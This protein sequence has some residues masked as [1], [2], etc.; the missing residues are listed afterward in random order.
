MT[1]LFLGSCHLLYAQQINVTNRGTVIRIEQDALVSINGNY[2]DISG[3]GDPTQIESL[4]NDPESG[5]AVDAPIFLSGTLRIT[6]NIENYSITGS[7]LIFEFEGQ[8][9]TGKVILAGISDQAIGGSKDSYFP[10]LE[11]NKTGNVLLQKSIF[12]DNNLTLTAGNINLN[13][14]NIT[15]GQV[16]SIVSETGAN[17]IFG[18]PGNV[19]TA[20]YPI[21]PSASVTN[22]RGIGLGYTTTIQN[23]SNVKFYRTHGPGNYMVAD[24]VNVLRVYRMETATMD[25]FP[26]VNFYYHDAELNGVPE[27]NIALYF[28]NNGGTSW[29]KASSTVNTTSNIV[30]AYNVAVTSGANNLFTLA[31]SNCST[32]NR[33]DVTITSPSATIAGNSMNICEQQSFAIAVPNVST[34]YYQWT[35]PDGNRN[36]YDYT[37]ASIVRPD[38]TGT[39]SIFARN[40]RGCENTSAL[41]VNVRSI[42]SPQFSISPDPNTTALCFGNELTLDDISTTADMSAITGWAWD[43]GDVSNATASI[44]SPQFTYTTFGDKTPSLVVTSQYGCVSA[45]ATRNITIQSL[46]TPDFTITDGANEITRICEDIDAHFINHS[47]YR[48]YEGN[49]TSSLSYHWDFGDT[50]SSSAH[51]PIHAFTTHNTYTITLT[52]T[53]TATTCYQTFSKDLIINPEPIPMFTPTIGG[54]AIAEVCAGVY[55][56]FDNTTTMPGGTG[57]TYQWDFDDGNASTAVSPVK[58]FDVADLN[59]IKLTATSVEFGCY[60]SHT[61]DVLVNPPPTGHFA[62]QDPDICLVEE[63]VFTNNSTISSGTLTYQWDFADG[64]SSTEATPEVRHTYSQPQLYKVSLT[65][66][67]NK[68][69]TNVVTRNLTVHPTPVPAF[70]QL[71][72]CDGNEVTF[73]N[74]SVIQSDAIA[75]FLWDFNDGTTSAATAP[76]HIFPQ[77]GIHSVS[78]TATSTFGC[79]NTISGSVEVYRNPVFNLGASVAG[80]TVPYTIDPSS[81]VAAYL[82][83]G[84]TFTWLNAAQEPLANTSQL[85]VNTSGV[86]RA[87]ITTP[88]PQSCTSSIAV[89]FFIFK[90][91]S[92][93]LDTVA[94]AQIILDAERGLP[95]EKMNTDQTSYEWRKNGVVVST[96]QTITAAETG[97]YTVTVTRTRA[98]SSCSSSDDVHVTIELPLTVTLPAQIISCEGQSLLLDAGV[99]ADTYLWTHIDTGAPMGTSSTLSVTQSGTYKLEVTNGTCK[100][101]SVSAITISPL[102]AVSFGVSASSGCVGQPVTLTDYSF[103]NVGTITSS[104]WNFG[105]NT[106]A[107]NQAVANKS[108]VS[109]GTYSIT[110]TGTT[111]HGCNNTYSLQVVINPAPNVDF[112]ITDVCTNEFASIQNNTLPTSATFAWNFGDGTESN[113]F[114]PNKSFTDDGQFNVTLT[115]SDLGCSSSVTRTVTINPLPD[116]DFGDQVTTCGNSLLLDALNPG[117]SYKWFDPSNGNTTLSTA[118]QYTVSTNQSIGLEITN[119]FGC[120][121]N[122]VTTVNLNVPIV[123]NLGPNRSVCDA[124]VLDAGYF[125]GAQYAWSTSE[126]TRAVDVASSGTYSV[127]I[128]DQNGCT[129]NASVLLEVNVTPVVS[130]GADKS[131]CEGEQLTLDAGFNSMFTYSWSTGA[132]SSSINVTTAGNY[133]VLVSNSNCS[134]SESVEVKVNAA[135]SA[136]FTAA[137]TCSGRT[138]SFNN[139]SVNNSAGNLTYLWNFGDGTFSALAAPYKM[140]GTPGSQ[141][142]SLKT[143]NENQC[144][145]EIS[146]QVVI[147]A[148]PLAGFTVDQGCTTQALTF[149]NTTAISGSSTLSY[150]WDFGNGDTRVGI[151][152]SYAYSTSGNYIINLQVAS[153]DGCT[154]NYLQEVVIG[155]TPSLS[156]WSPVVATCN[157]SVVLDAGNAGS[158]YLWSFNNAATQTI[159]VSTTGQYQVAITSAD[160]CATTGEVDVVFNNQVQPQL[161]DTAEGCGSVTLDPLVNAATYLWSTGAQSRTLNVAISDTYWIQ[162]ISEDLCIGRDTTSVDIHPVPVVD[163]GRDRKACD[164]ETLNLVAVST[165]PVAYNWS[166]GATA[167]N[168]NVTQTG[169]YTVTVTTENNCTDTDEISVIFNQLPIL[170]FDN[171]I[172]ACGETKLDAQNPG[173]TYTW[174]TGSC[175]QIITATRSGIYS[176]EVVNVHN[177]I[178]KDTVDITILPLPQIELGPDQTLCNGITATLDAGASSDKYLW[179]DNSTGR[180]LTA[181]S[182]GLYKVTRT[183]AVGCSASDDVRIAVRPPL[184]VDLGE[185][186][187]LCN[188]SGVF[189]SAKVDNVHYQWGSSTGFSSQRKDISADKA[190]TYWVKITDDFLCVAADTVTISPTTQNITASF[191]APSVVGRGDLVH[192]AQL[193]EPK[194]TTFSWQFGDGGISNEENPVHRY[195]RIGE[196]TSTLVVSNGVCTDTLSKTITVRNGRS[197]VEPTLQ[198]PELIEIV[199][200]T[201]YPNPS[202]GAVKLEI[203][204]TAE[205]EVWVGVYSLKGITIEEKRKL[206]FDDNIEFDLSK[207]SDGVYLVRIIVEGKTKVFKLL[208]SGGYQ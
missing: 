111:N 95:G 43:F 57:I 158:T 139:L 169:N 204:L 136:N 170:N 157:S 125:P 130:L 22:Y 23:F 140:Y 128:T 197:E 90:P 114:Q 46:P 50:N 41:T 121:I 53:A 173:S 94:C 11:L 177:C 87:V 148:T 63:A 189:M 115:A 89:P 82:P 45:P 70:T 185:D 3:T 171:T 142:I 108:Y 99:V 208:K 168:I 145:S 59:A 48:D 109:P 113:L 133:N 8:R 203:T 33:P 74:N 137:S 92:L 34:N 184:V 112:A 49:E 98:G 138:V 7:A 6:G 14:F 202:R 51:S 124:E 79:R 152:P 192:F 52:A 9:L 161:T 67:S 206:L 176:I 42:P 160:G 71:N 149:S 28:S 198:L 107:Q 156:E 187:L 86:Y 85:V 123:V 2:A 183:N 199:K 165:L 32:G 12:I 24:A 175:Q 64:N 147:H 19:E 5:I 15:L 141:A 127:S 18:Y 180:Y 80:C 21:N 150:Q 163:L 191:L 196:F 120:K 103:T 155:T 61:V 117:S 29:V 69:C 118:Q 166:S 35:T 154:D 106:T 75:N 195:F 146:K 55:V 182:T 76:K 73:Y 47:S 190:G 4:G 134:V 16:G 179:S 40:Q 36:A 131:I 58:Q 181:G 83:A 30:T 96:Q 200:A 100:A 110:L 31:T 13:G 153:S 44:K 65:R 143:T 119:A 81:D 201:L 172:T 151:T 62:V 122:D 39:Y 167:A 159:S 77:Y 135:P 174:S 78:L 17:R 97:L 101:S 84:S 116:F 105:D 10:N 91:V 26:S 104:A 72:A 66:T 193:S 129:A 164:G 162:V 126:T 88:S 25:I 207:E 60:E 20:S 37:I 102:P 144:S 178:V 186:R 132:A 194:P 27:A 188:N 1:L 54:A 56:L 68:G 93:G 205:A 38:D